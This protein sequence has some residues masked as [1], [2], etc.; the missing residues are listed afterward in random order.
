MFGDLGLFA[1]LGGDALEASRTFQ[2]G[3]VSDRVPCNSKLV[4]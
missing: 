3:E 2:S 4:C 1:I